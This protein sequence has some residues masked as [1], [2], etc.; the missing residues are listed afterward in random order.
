MPLH[1]FANLLKSIDRCS[2]ARVRIHCEGNRPKAH[3]SRAFRADHAYN[4]SFSVRPR[5]MR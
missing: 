1:R 5:L 4:E 2:V 3:Y